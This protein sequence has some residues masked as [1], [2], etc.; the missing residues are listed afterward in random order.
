MVS[1]IDNV[2]KS[3]LIKAGMQMNGAVVFFA[4]TGGLGALGAVG[5]LLGSLFVAL[6]LALLRMYKRDFRPHS[7]VAI[8]EN[9]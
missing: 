6:L 2:V 9:V 3:F 7:G 8:P 1:L 4:L 5:P